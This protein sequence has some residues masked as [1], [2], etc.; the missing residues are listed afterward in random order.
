MWTYE[1][2]YTILRLIC[3]SINGTHSFNAKGLLYSN[4]CLL[5]VNHLNITIFSMSSTYTSFNLTRG[6][7]AHSVSSAP[8]KTA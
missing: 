4:H 2:L 1:S 8:Y 5:A 7:V 6:N 3:V